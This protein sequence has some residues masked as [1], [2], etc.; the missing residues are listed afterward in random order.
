MERFTAIYKRSNCATGASNV[1]RFTVF[2][3]DEAGAEAKA[4]KHVHKLWQAA[5]DRFCCYA[6]KRVCNY[7]FLYVQGEMEQ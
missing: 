2:A 7:D 3:R 4:R 6:T 1:Y 5:W